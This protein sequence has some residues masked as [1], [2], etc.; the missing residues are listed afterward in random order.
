MISGVPLPAKNRNGVE[1]T[2][3]QDASSD[4]LLLNQRFRSKIRKKPSSKPIKILGNLI[5]YGESPK[6]K[7]ES[8]CKK[9]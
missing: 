7:M 5:A 2:T 1:S 9:R 8:F 4:T 3:R 6:I